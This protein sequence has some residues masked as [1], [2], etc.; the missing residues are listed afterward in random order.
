MANKNIQIKHKEGNNWNNLYPFTT[1]ENVF[2]NNG[3]S[4]K[5]RLEVEQ[6]EREEIGRTTI[7]R[8]GDM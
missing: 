7:I 3:L 6:Q 4:L 2:E 8:G 5:E 1:T